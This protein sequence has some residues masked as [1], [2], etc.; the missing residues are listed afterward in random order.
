MTNGTIE[1]AD[2]PEEHRYEL[3]VEGELAAIAE[4]RD[5][6]GGGVRTFTH[7][8]VYALFEGRGLGNRLAS[9]ALDYARAKGLTI[10]PQ[11]PSIAGYIRTHPEYGDLLRP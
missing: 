10:V 9:A 6:P 4:Y 1:I 8:V 3:W 5:S 7:T 11:C 2:Y